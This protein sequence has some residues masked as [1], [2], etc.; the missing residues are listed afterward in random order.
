MWEQGIEFGEALLNW[1]ILT[2]E[3]VTVYVLLY[4]VLS[5]VISLGSKIV[6]KLGL[7]SKD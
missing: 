5:G 3:I 6:K 7:S 2:G 4:G 1:L